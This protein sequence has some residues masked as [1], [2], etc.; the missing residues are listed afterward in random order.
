MYLHTSGT[1]LSQFKQERAFNMIQ[2][3]G[4]VCDYIVYTLDDVQRLC[5]EIL[6]RHGL[7][8]EQS[9]ALSKVITAG[10]RDECRSHGVYRIPGC[11][12]TIKSP[13]FNSSA[14]PDVSTVKGPVLRVD[15][16]FGF[17]CLALDNST[18]ELVSRAN[19]FGLAALV[20]NNCFHFSALWYE[21]EELA[22]HGLV[23]VALNPSQRAVAPAGG[24]RPLFGT[25]PI[26][27]GW[28]RPTG[29]PYV[30][31]FATSEVARGE[32]ELHRQNAKAMPL[33][34]AIDRDGNPTTD[35]TA[36]LAGAMLTFG[37]HKGSAL[38]TMIELI[39]G[40]LI[41]DMMSF[42]SS[43][44]DAGAGAA[45]CHGELILAFSPERLLGID[46]E[47]AFTR[48]EGLFQHMIEQGA[49]LPS[50]RRYEAR[51]RSTRDGVKITRVQHELLQGLLNSGP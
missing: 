5:L 50:Q 48:A 2:D 49:R 39:A 31:D 36:G 17:S 20:I 28:P 33:G 14:I 19:E 11:V 26:A 7:S 3:S 12:K 16:K 1:I 24:T 42:E 23:S 35:P 34:W 18:S 9:Y 15:A 10:E 25:N 44:F 47:A 37:G 6:T 40:P 30:F 8:G 4:D 21:V 27:F 32:I 22:K 45:P 13:K 41:N 43:A 51:M 38:S 46:K 29:N